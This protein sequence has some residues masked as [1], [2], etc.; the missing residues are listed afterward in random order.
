MKKTS[1]QEAVFPACVNEVPEIC[2]VITEAARECG[3]D[4]KNLWK[5]EIALDEACTNI[6]CYGY[7]EG[8]EGKIHV[9]WDCQENDFTVVIE[10]KG[11]A[12]D[13]SEPTTPDFSS[14]I[15][16]RKAG[17]LGRYIMRKFLD[18]MSYHRENGKNT[19]RLVKKLTSP[20]ES[21]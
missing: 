4:D 13:Q 5:L 16:Q 17:G 6:A 8:C 15:C 19:L 9:Q 21:D 3:M 7:E 18:D 12:F 11:L 2:R 20:E 1:V 10:D 14:D